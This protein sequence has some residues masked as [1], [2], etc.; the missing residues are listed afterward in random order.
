MQGLGNNDNEQS[1]KTCGWLAIGT[2]IATIVFY[3]VGFIVMIAVLVSL[4]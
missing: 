1:A 4:P 2:N 3:V